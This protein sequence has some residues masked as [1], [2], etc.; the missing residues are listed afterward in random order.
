VTLPHLLL[1]PPWCSYNDNWLQLLLLPFT[2]DLL[3]HSLLVPFIGNHQPL[4]LLLLPLPPLLL[5][6]SQTR[7]TLIE[8]PQ[9]PQKCLLCM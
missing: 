8:P 6:L 9:P 5:L 4:L 3:L 1:V 7:A 2:D